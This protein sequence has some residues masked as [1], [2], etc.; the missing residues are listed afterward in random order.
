M[1]FSK[2]TEMHTN[3]FRF[4][5]FESI[6]SPPLL[7]FIKIYLK[8]AFD[9]IYNFGSIANQKVIYIQRTVNTWIQAFYNVV[10][11]KT[12]QSYR[13]NATLRHTL[14]LIVCLGQC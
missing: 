4:G 14:F 13:L 9:S 6:C 10:Y 12:E 3:C 8:L 7:N 5:K 11:L 2:M 1:S